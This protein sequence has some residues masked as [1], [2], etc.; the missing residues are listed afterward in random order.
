MV[1]PLTLLDVLNGFLLP[2]SKTNEISREKKKEVKAKLQI[3]YIETLA[4][5]F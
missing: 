3:N 1:F 5:E 4:K 2:R